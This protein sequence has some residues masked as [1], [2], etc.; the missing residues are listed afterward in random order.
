MCQLMGKFRLRALVTSV[1]SLSLLAGAAA[2]S[3]G[4]GSQTP[5]TPAIST[6]AGGDTQTASVAQSS[7]LNFTAAGTAA[8]S[9]LFYTTGGESGTV[10]SLMAPSTTAS[11]KT[12]IVTVPGS[13][14]DDSWGWIA[15]QSSGSASWPAATYTVSLNITRA[16][17]YVR[18]TAVKI[19]RVNQYGGPSTSGLSTVG[20]TTGLNVSLG[21]TG[22]KTFT[23][24]GAAQTANTTDKLAV[25]FY[26]SSTNASSQ[27]FGF[28]AGY[29]ALSK[30]TTGS[31][32]AAT[33]A[34]TAAP[35][36]TTTTTTAI[37]HITVVLMENYDYSQVIGNSAAPFINSFAKANALF[38]NSHAITHPSEPN[39]LA[40]FSGSTQGLTSDAC[41]VTFSGANL[42]SELAAKGLS[43]AGYAEDMPSSHSACSAYASSSVASKYLYWRKHVPWADFTNVPS[44]DFHAY[45]GPLSS[46]AAQ[47]TFITPNICD[48]MHDCGVA[49]G[50]K[51]AANNL[52]SIVNYDKANDGLLILTSDE[53]EYS[54]TNQVMTIFAGPMVK[55]GQY[56]EY[57]NHY[58]I[59]R[60]IEQNFG[61]PLLSGATTAATVT[62]AAY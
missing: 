25:K 34:P 16:N 6:P 62:T 5:F 8:A 35:L 43:F 48:D 42:A 29:G 10:S 45:T 1:A 36:T 3:G 50:D 49:A 54:S 13:S 46:L 39:Y 40:L 11:R 55:P 20:Q 44:G 4:A 2:C 28:D 31:G 12:A 56:S 59:L 7:A 21:T 57:I 9:T 14:Y 32:T 61:L 47:V 37:K 15:S 17:P 24:S 30:L 41:P 60:L 33:P 52:P 58:S 23:I 51:W 22:V 53:G 18:V 27:T 38:T 19:Y 26:T